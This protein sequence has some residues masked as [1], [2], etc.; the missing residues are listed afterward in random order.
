[1]NSLQNKKLSRKININKEEVLKDA[2]EVLDIEIENLL[3]ARNEI[4]DNFVKLVEKILECSG[5]VILIGMGKSGH[6]GNKITATMA[7]LGIPS[8]SIHPGEAAHGDLGMITYEDIV[9]T[10]SNSGETE[11][12]IQLIPSIKKIG[13][14]LVSVTSNKESTLSKYADLSIKL[15]IT[16]EA[17][18]YDL[19]PTTSTTV[20]LA[21]GDALAV[22]LSKLIGFKPEDFA[23][24]HP[25]GALGKRLLT[26]VE[27][28]MCKEEDNPIINQN[29]TL[30]QAVLVMS[31]K[32]L[33]GVNIV[34]NNGKLVGLLTDGDLRRLIEKYD[35]VRNL[36]IKD[37]MTKNPINVEEST[38]A[39]DA[40]KVME[41]RNKKVSVLPVIDKY[42]VCTGMIRL[43][44]L[45]EAGI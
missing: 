27:D 34:D 24:Y 44:D 31:S 32:G 23:L 6:V 30:I 5:R 39:V 15:T 4:G 37:I 35:S 40:L 8:F 26:T 2:R 29:A 20:T 18:Q 19:A 9:I 7:S 43:H 38:L 10:I 25:K 3:I 1:M 22:V 14:F 17:E 12:V 42:G 21:F 13:A 16:R 36:I 28:L 45:V 41:S 11:E 33:G